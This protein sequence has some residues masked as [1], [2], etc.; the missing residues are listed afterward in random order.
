MGWML[1]ANQKY[2]LPLIQRLDPNR[3]VGALSIIS[4]S[5]LT[6]PLRKFA[7]G[8]E[9]DDDPAHIVWKGL[10]NS[11]IGG[12]PVDWLNK[13]NATMDLVPELVVDKYNG[14]GFE[15]FSG[16]PGSIAMSAKAIS[17]AI[18]DGTF[19]KQDLRKMKR[20]IPLIEAW[21]LRRPV[22]AFID[23]LDI[24]EKPEN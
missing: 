17:N 7:S 12:L 2:L 22:N 8:K 20:I 6:D 9:I 10:L 19:N 15:L 13:A 23:A 5:M 18:K 1:Q 21:E 11:G 16:I 14:K 24:P 3:V 4:A